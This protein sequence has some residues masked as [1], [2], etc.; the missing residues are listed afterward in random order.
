[1]G[2]EE[3]KFKNTAKSSSFSPDDLFYTIRQVHELINFDVIRLTGGEPLLYG[4][5]LPLVKRINSLGID[6]I[7]L[8]TNGLLLER[9]AKP[10]KEAGMRSVNVSLDAVD[11]DVFFLMSRRNKVEKIIRGIDAAI[12]AGMEVKLNAV[13]MKGIN[14]QQ[15]IPLLRFASSRRISIRYLEI[16]AM[17]HLYDKAAQYLLSKD[18]ILHTIARHYDFVPVLRKDHATANYWRT[19]EGNEFGIIANESTPF[20]HDC[21]RLRLDSEG[22]IYGCLSDDHPIS[23]KNINNENEL[24]QKLLE[25]LQQ[26]QPLRFKGSPLSMLH[27]GG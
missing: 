27:I 2:E 9:L 18:E 14:D 24:R 17:G 12:G 13:M 19:S 26:K 1:M 23:L 21:N 6:N 25:A 20:C 5:L 16:M 22:N 15:I 11:E 10:L 8:T 4:Q 3:V 7:R